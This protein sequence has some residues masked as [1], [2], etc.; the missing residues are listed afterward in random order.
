[1][2][3]KIVNLFVAAFSLGVVQAASA[4]DMPTKM[5]VKAAPIVAPYNWTGFYVG[6]NAGGAWNRNT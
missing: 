3:S 6:V 5:P 4:A 1:M 2:R